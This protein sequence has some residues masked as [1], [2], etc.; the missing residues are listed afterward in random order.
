MSF[1]LGNVHN[2][3][4]QSIAVDVIQSTNLVDYTKPITG[5]SINVVIPLIGT[6]SLIDSPNS[7]PN[8]SSNV[9]AYFLDKHWV[10][11]YTGDSI[12]INVS[13]D[14][15]GQPSIDY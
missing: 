9:N 10:I 11:S 5:G 2:Y 1:Y 12:T 13:I 3:Y 6:L 4:S 14:T 15:S 7:G 8:G